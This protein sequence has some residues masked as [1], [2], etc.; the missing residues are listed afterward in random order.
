MERVGVGIIGVG[1]I[2]KGVDASYQAA[3]LAVL[4][5][6]L[7]R[8]VG[9]ADRRFWFAATAAFVVSMAAFTAIAA[10]PLVL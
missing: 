8:L 6:F 9:R 5:G 1:G 2:E 10:F 3:Q 4:V 7:I